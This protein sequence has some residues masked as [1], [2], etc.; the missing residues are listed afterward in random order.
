MLKRSV[1]ASGFSNLSIARYFAAQGVDYLLFDLNNIKIHTVYEICAWVEGVK[2]LI[3]MDADN[4]LDLEEILIKIQ[5]YAVGS[6]DHS[7][8][9]YLKMN[10]FDLNPYF[11][12]AFPNELKIYHQNDMP[13][14]FLL[15]DYR[16]PLLG[17]QSSD[18]GLWIHVLD[19][20]ALSEAESFEFL[21]I[22]FEN[23]V[24]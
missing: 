13:T 7:I 24:E 6:S 23:L 9:E 21:D 3:K 20:S 12:L 5:P 19:S 11:D 14:Q 22:F 18:C 8:V 1:V 17:P 10:F 2:I 15:H 16:I 4:I